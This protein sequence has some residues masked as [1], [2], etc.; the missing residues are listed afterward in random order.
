MQNYL[1]F[2]GGAMCIWSESIQ[3]ESIQY[4]YVRAMSIPTKHNYSVLSNSIRT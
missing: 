1:S 3:T 4:D 2:V